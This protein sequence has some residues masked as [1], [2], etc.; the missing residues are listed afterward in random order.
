MSAMLRIAREEWRLLSRDRVAV[1]GLTL[2][3]LLTAVAS[4]TAWEQRRSTDAQRTR[5]QA[6]VDHEFEAQP[7]RHPHRMVHYGHFVFRPLNPLAAF[8][9][10]VDAYTGHTLFLEGHRQNSANFGDVRQSS[11]LLRFG[12]LTPAFVLQ[13][14]APL[15]LIFVGHASLAR[16]RESGTLRV[17]LAQGVAPGQ[18]VAGKVLAMSAVAAAALLPALLALLWIGVATPAPLGLAAVLVAGYGLWLLIW[19]LGIV[20]LSAWFGRARDALVALLAVWAISVVL[21]PRLAP[22][23]AASAMA[24]PTR[25]ETDIAVARDLAALGDSHN[26]NDPYF[27]GFKKKVLAQYGVSRVEDLPVN[28]KGLLGM[29]GERLTSALFVRYA[30]DGFERQAAQL[31]LVDNFAWLSPVIALRRLSMAAAGTDLQNYRRFV[32]QAERHRYRLVQEL[33][34]LQAEKLSFASDRSSR[35]NRIGAEHWH[36]MADFHYEAAPPIEALQRTAPA[37]GV[38]LLWLAAL[39]AL[40]VLAAHRLGRIKR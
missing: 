24:L 27:A 40:L 15:L 34:R 31:R 6:Q 35:D 5:H 4:F 29:E 30:N 38:L 18:I 37:A 3:L 11:L 9:A 28:Y 10:G 8:D 22:E 23:L 19:A 33:N 21:V 17:L 32:E 13:V 20:G 26:P 14:L 2:L 39:T 12:Q 36:G 1:L 25:F 7:E 16:E